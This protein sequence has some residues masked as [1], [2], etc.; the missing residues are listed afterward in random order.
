VTTCT[1]PAGGLVDPDALWTDI[2]DAVEPRAENRERY[3]A[4]Y[5]GYLR[6]YPRTAD[7]VYALAARPA[8][9]REE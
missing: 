6:L 1:T 3:D 5:A 7:T 8:R 2:V 4:L 9:R